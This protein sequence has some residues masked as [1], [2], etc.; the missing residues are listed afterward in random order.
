MAEATRIELEIDEEHQA[1][2]ERIA[3]GLGLSAEEIARRALA[4]YLTEVEEDNRY[5]G[6]FD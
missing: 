3:K 5:P 1:G 6:L 4:A 2:L